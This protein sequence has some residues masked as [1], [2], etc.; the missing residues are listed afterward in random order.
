MKLKMKNFHYML[1][2]FTYYYVLKINISYKGARI[3]NFIK[4]NRK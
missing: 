3:N 2:T 4:N 1:I